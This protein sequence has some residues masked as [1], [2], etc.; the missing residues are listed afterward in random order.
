MVALS[1]ILTLLLTGIAYAQEDPPEAHG[2]PSW[3]IIGIAK[4][5]SQ[6]YWDDQGQFRY[7]D[8]RDG[9]D[10]EKG[11]FQI[12]PAAFAQVAKKGERFIRLTSDQR[13]SLAVACRYLHF[14]RARTRSWDQTV[15]CYNT[16]LNGS[17]SRGAQ[18]LL[19]VK[20]AAG[21]AP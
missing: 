13:L 17:P 12:T 14:L 5:E 11:A 21:I 4:A 16:G 18:Y 6:S 15:S 3:C 19:L 9:K 8:Q 20:L 7:I 1:L 2:I 10:G